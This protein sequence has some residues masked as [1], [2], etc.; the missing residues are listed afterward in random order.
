MVTHFGSCISSIAGYLPCRTISNKELSSHT[1][2]SPEWIAERTGIRT[3]HYAAD[4]EDVVEM[5]VEAG[6]RAMTMAGVAEQ[7]V[8]LV[9]LATST[10]RTRVPGG[11]PQVA[12]GL[13]LELSGAFDVNAGCAGFTYALATAAAA[14]RCGDANN[15]LVVAAE[16]MSEWIRPE[17]PDTFVIFGDGAGA[18]IVARS[19]EERIWPPVW[20]SDG[21]RADI[22]GIGTLTSG[23][24]YPFMNGPLVYRWSTSKLPSVAHRACER[25]G[26]KLSDIAW[27]VCHQAN[28]RIIDTIARNLNF[29][30]DHVARDVIDTGN[31][32]AASIPL[33]LAHLYEDGMISTGDLV[34]LLGFG[35]GLTFSGQVV[36]MP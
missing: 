20:G 25:A 8:D 34:L 26:L 13:G 15:V 11:A 36:R 16:R 21:T 33:A 27:L 3:R 24:E 31:T 19:D 18:A 23:V 30:E 35:A 2:V 17:Y 28:R 32:S 1:T 6:R 4:G 22:L 29:P 9:I 7:E 5:A 14:V 12:S 10:R